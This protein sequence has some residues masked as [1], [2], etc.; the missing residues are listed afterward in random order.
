M[1]QQDQHYLA[2]ILVLFLVGWFHWVFVS[3]PGTVGIALG[4]ASVELQKRIFDL[5]HHLMIPTSA[6]SSSDREAVTTT[7]DPQRAVSRS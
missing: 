5:D 6:H 1:T 2:C 3:Q 4:L 7:L